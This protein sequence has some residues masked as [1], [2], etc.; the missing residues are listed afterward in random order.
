MSFPILFINE[1]ED[2]KLQ[3]NFKRIT[4]FFLS[5]RLL[6]AEFKHFKITFPNAVTNAK[7]RHNLGFR[8]LDIIQTSSIGPGVLTWNYDKFDANFLDVTT[9]GAVTVRA[10]VGSYQEG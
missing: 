3:E 2:E 7:F 10:F 5:Q 4:E 6:G 8:P 1:I 9:T